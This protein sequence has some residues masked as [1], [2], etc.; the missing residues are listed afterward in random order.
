MCFLTPGLD[1]LLHVHCKTEAAE[2][3]TCS[4]S[5]RNWAEA[6]NWRLI[7]HNLCSIPNNFHKSLCHWLTTRHSGYVHS[8]IVAPQLGDAATG[9]ELQLTL[10]IIKPLLI[11]AKSAVA[12]IAL[13]K[14]INALL[15]I[16]LPFQV[17]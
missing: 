3:A 12:F 1:H 10:P 14:H 15:S 13:T 4:L 9:Y 2:H 11:L 16:L 7:Q 6:W 8:E 5:N 17:E